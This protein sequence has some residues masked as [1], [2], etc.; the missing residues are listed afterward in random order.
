MRITFIRRY[1][2]ALAL[3]AAIGLLAPAAVS[4]NPTVTVDNGTLVGLTTDGVHVF[5]GVPYATPPTGV[6]RWRPPE[7]HE[8]WQGRRFAMSFAPECPQLPYPEGSFF[9]RGI[10][11]S[12]E[13]CL[14]LNVWTT[15]LDQQ[16]DRPVMVW[17]HGGGLT[18]GSG[19]SPWYDGAALAR[20]GVVVVTF[21]YRLGAFGYLAHP[22]LSEESEHGAS[23]NY[24][25][26]D[27][28]AALE[29]V[30]D[31]I[32]RFG[33]DP[34]NVT[35]FGESAGAWSVH[36]LT[37]SPLAQG[38]FHKAIGQSGAH[39]YPIP[40]LA[41]PRFGLQAHE[42]SGLALED[43]A[44]VDSL[45]ALRGLSAD[46]VLGAFE[47]MDYAGLA[48]PNVDGWVF[49]EQIATIYREGRQHRVPLIL[50][51]NA[52]EGTTL[53]LGRAPESADA[54]ERSVRQRFGAL[55]EG[56]LQ[57]YDPATDHVGAF[58]ASFRDETFTWPMRFWARQAAAAGQE[59]WLYYFT[60][61]PP[62]DRQGQLGAYHAAE[63]RYVF[64][65]VD[66]G[67]TATAT[68]EALADAMSDYWVSFA[69]TGRPVAPD[70][71]AWP[72]YQRDRE[73]Y[74]IFGDEIRAAE[75]LLPDEMAL[76]DEAAA[77]RW[78]A[79]EQD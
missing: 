55:A 4:A 10:S 46:R 56:F 49:P 64:G 77:R 14:Y 71:P 15:S 9:E 37:A 40:E 65:N 66:T 60:R 11:P 25:T 29:W 50:G 57:V 36:Q 33:G 23:G 7:P 45:E 53:A 8:D 61:E 43:A 30:R 24:G 41:R 76:F 69:A 31:N 22:A 47:R 79:P 42:D 63:I 39:A 3:A 32:A 58:L 19:A 75:D 70:A 73:P 48:R 21:N 52:D 62:G 17:I 68:D 16:A 38:L 59:V 12:S 1:A 54:F 51:S 35:I 72:R 44:G 18:R 6:R 74:L 13:D 2:G 20:K 27:Q 67:M 34:G 28:I 78:E 5:K 26:L